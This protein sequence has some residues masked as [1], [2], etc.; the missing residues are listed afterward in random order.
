MRYYC[1]APG[2]RTWFALETEAE[3]EAE[4]KL[5]GHAVA[6]F[7]R[8]ARAEA[9]SCYKPS[10]ALSFIE[11]DIGLK[12]H[13][14]RTMP[15]FLTLRDDEGAGLAT[16]MLPPESHDGASFRIIIVGPANADPYDAHGDAIEA[17]ED[18]TGLELDR[19]D[20]YPYLR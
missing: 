11:R 1:D 15:L 13:V 6:R 12:D 10:A 18:R 16:A 4:S 7:Y 3:A 9:L 19:D 2:G 17:L 5:M 20:C 14:T 8:L